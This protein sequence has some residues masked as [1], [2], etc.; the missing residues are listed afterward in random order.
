M[1]SNLNVAIQKLPFIVGVNPHIRSVYQLYLDSFEQ[2]K[3]FGSI[4][5]QSAQD[6]FDQ[7]LRDLVHSHQDVIPT[8]AKGNYLIPLHSQLIIRI[9]RVR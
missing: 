4:D 5:E 7:L 9:L 1:N 2:I 3:D 6:R 8:L